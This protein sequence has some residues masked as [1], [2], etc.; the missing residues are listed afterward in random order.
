MTIIQSFLSY[1]SLGQILT[2]KNREER[3]TF[4]Y[5]R[6]NYNIGIKKNEDITEEL[7]RNL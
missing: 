6:R 1:G 7:E 4:P 5:S 3:K 2:V